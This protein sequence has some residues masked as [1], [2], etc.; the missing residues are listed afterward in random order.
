MNRYLCIFEGRVQGVG[1]RYT[2]VQIVYRIGGLTGYV[3]NLSNGAVEIQIQG[4]QENIDEFFKQI[5]QPDDWIKIY[6]Y[7]IKKIP[8]VKEESSF[9]VKY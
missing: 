6:D 5:L 1:F 3:R 9:D 8:V 2:V 7:Q 4:K